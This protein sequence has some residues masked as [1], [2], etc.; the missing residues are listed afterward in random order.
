M[1]YLIIT[2]VIWSFSFSIIGNYLSP[3]INSWTLAFF[4]SLVAFIFF[5]PWLRKSISYKY[6]I[7]I[8]SIGAL[9]IGLM[10]V[11]YLTAF[12]YTTV[13]RILLF[14]ITTPFYVV[15]ISNLFERKFKLPVYLLSIF[16]IIGALCLRTTYFDKNDLIGFV[17]IQS[18]NLCFA[19]GQI[20][21]RRFKQGDWNPVDKFHEFTYFFL[22]ALL[23]SSVGLIISPQ[24]LSLPGSFVEWILVLW[25]GGIATG[26]GYYLWNRGSELVSSTTLAVMNNLVIPIALLVETVFFTRTV[27]IES[28]I[29]GT[30]IIISTIVASVRFKV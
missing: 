30:I 12:N 5:L 20:L 22:G 25:L 7:R 6:L 29:I 17:L 13:Q 21:Y 8:A 26:V 9:Q 23:I 15:L 4:R 19:S 16:S 2:T 10:Y 14:T 18:A 1:I 28:Y 27:N 11:F 3:Q 24:G